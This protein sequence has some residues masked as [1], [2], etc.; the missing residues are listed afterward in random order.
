MIDW[1]PL[2][3]DAASVHYDL[4]RWTFDQRAEVAATFA[5]EE[6]PHAWDG[7]EVVVPEELEA[8]VD[9][10]FAELE[11]RLGIDAD[12]EVVER[13]FDEAGGITEYDLSELAPG[14]RAALAAALVDARVPHRW[15]VASLEV[16][17][18]AEEAV[19][20]IMDR[21]DAGDVTVLDDSESDER[22]V[23]LAELFG[24][25]DR[26]RRDPLDPEGLRMLVGALD[27]IEP[28]RPP[29]GTQL[30]LWRRAYELADRLA[31]FLA[32]GDEPDELAAIT[33][34]EQ[35]HELLADQV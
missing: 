13:G 21:V 11:V 31:D 33:T 10:L 1:N 24:L 25:A 14:D 5:D 16:P 6:I 28:D 34:A 18:A 9:E 8:R 26:L 3:P 29:Y 2:D 22:T 27:E 4:S 20:E 17:T 23:G 35:L 30:A 12:A 15:N 19:E 7:D 32:G